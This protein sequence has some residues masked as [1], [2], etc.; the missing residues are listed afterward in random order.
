MGA[1]ICASET[2]V[3]LCRWSETNYRYLHLGAYEDALFTGDIEVTFTN[4]DTGATWECYGGKY[5]DM[6]DKSSG[7]YQYTDF[8]VPE[9]HF[10]KDFGY[11][12]IMIDESPNH[13]DPPKYD[14]NGFYMNL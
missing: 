2:P 4:P 5:T 1:G 11:Y 6:A 12:W 9:G 3:D 7:K 8:S 14:Y 13:Y 10:V